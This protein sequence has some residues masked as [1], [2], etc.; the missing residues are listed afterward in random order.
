MN[1]RQEAQERIGER[2]DPRVLEPSPPADQTE[3]WFADDPVAR[4]DV[5]P[6][7]IVVSPVDTGDLRWEELAGSD[8]ELRAWCADRWLGPYRR[9][10][11]VPPALVPTRL[12]LHRLAEHVISPARRQANGKIGLRYT[13]HGFGTP[14]F[15]SD[16]QVRVA[17]AGLVVEDSGFERTAP[18]TTLDAAA[19][20]VGRRALPADIELG[21]EPLEVDPE[22]A[23]FLG[24]WY[25]FAASVLE[26]LRAGASAAQDATRV[27]LWPEHFDLAMVLGDASAGARASYGLSPGDERHPEPYV[28]VGPWVEPQPSELWQAAGFSGAEL[29]YAEL[30]AAADQRAAALE[31]LQTRAAA[32]AG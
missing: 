21:S 15:G 2:Y 26:E 4:G 10:G 9:L 28:Y 27:Q 31:F 6:G 7:R 13:H 8:A 32:L 12:A 22:A 17:G 30:A 19:D 14:L 16:M 29:A 3:P 1:A 23:A 11:P 24:D 18:I 25:G 5:T 20:H